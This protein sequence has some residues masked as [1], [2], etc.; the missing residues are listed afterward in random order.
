MVRGSLPSLIACFREEEEGVTIDLAFV[1]PQQD[2][3]KGILSQ[4]GLSLQ[5]Q[6]PTLFCSYFSFL[7][8]IHTAYIKN[9]YL[10]PVGGHSV[11]GQ[12]WA[13]F[14]PGSLLAYP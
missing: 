7:P 10:I 5:G 12:R 13:M 3:G 14:P 9:F 4:F 11:K 2:L 1:V 8:L 6:A